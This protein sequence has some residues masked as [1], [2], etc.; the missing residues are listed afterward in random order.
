MATI[1]SGGGQQHHRQHQPAI[2]NR[3]SMLLSKDENELIFSLLGKK[4]QTLS[5]SVVQLL[6]SEAP[7]HTKWQIRCT[8]VVCFVKDNPKRSYFIRVYDF[9]KRQLVWE[10]ELYNT[11]DYK[12]PRNFFHTFEAHDCMA[13][14]N[15]ADDREAKQFRDAI[16]GKLDERLKKKQEKRLQNQAQ[17]QQLPAI[18][19]TQTGV[20]AGQHFQQ[21]PT[22]RP[23]FQAIQNHTNQTPPPTATTWTPTTKKSANKKDTKR[24]VKLTKGDIGAPSN[25]QHV[26][27]I[28][29]N[30][31]TG[32]DLENVDHRMIQF[33]EEAG[34]SKEQLQDRDTRHFI[35][36]FIEK[37]GGI[38]A[39]LQEVKSPPPSIP[40]VPPNAKLSAPS[41]PPQTTPQQQ[42]SQQPMGGHTLHALSA[43]AHGRSPPKPFAPPIPANSVPPAHQ[44]PPPPPP[45]M[46]TTNIAPPPP[47]PP[48]PPPM[49]LGGAPPPP[50]PPMPVLGGGGGGG[51]GG[52]PPPPPPMSNLPA[53]SDNRSALMDQIRKGRQLQHVEPDSDSN[54]SNTS[55]NDDPRN[56]LLNQIKQ[57][58][59]LRPAENR[60]LK[61]VPKK[62]DEVGGLKEALMRAMNERSKAI[63]R[64]DDESDGGGDSDG[65]SDDDEWD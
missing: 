60:T 10:Q 48:M 13:G 21:Q 33:F 63:N 62:A 54:K 23:Q 22:N 17:Q 18:Q 56:A 6:L 53:V 29:W 9:D 52:P 39:A 58:V 3:S 24:R 55:S 65:G 42:V 19:P 20:N 49:P 30:P 16:H 40:S 25:F 26:Q 27:H 51:G 7:Y 14:L 28:G 1:S 37:H 36:D 11:F 15:F 2:D 41:L 43:P 50:P 12:C 38:E 45:P 34:I 31:N 5:T 35:Y 46:A 44:P 8:G 59:G 32:F 57:G 4:C 47:P 64:T 61:P